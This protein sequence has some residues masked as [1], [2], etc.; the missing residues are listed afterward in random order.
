MYCSQCGKQLEND[1]R[2]CPS[3]GA[4][5]EQGPAATIHTACK[6]CRGIMTLS[7]DGKSLVCPYCG[8]RELIP[9]HGA[10]ERERLKTYRELEEQRI[11]SQEEI[12]KARIRSEE[13]IRLEEQR[14]AAEKSTSDKNR[15][16]AALLCFLLGSLGAHR[17]YAGKIGTGILWLLTC[18]IFGVGW[19]VDLIMILCGSFR[20]AKGKQIK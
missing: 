9:D 16:V 7:E 3:C 13:K 4:R 8:A 11:R 17:F 12:E 10:A 20:D 15:W 1:A 5:A 6:A 14:Q 18:G 2:F 19:F